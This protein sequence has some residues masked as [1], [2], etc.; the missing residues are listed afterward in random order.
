MPWFEPWV[1]PVLST[2]SPFW[3]AT[4]ALARPFLSSRAHKLSKPVISVGNIVAGGVG[5]TEMAAAIAR[6]LIEKR[7]RVVIASRGYGSSWERKGGIALDAATA[8]S[9][10]F[11]DESIVV[12]K[13]APGAMVA[14][15]ADRYAVLTRHWEELNPDVVI[16]DDGFQ[17]F[18]LARDLDVLVHDFSLRWPIL[19]DLPRVFDKAKVRVS[20]SEVPSREKGW[21]RARYRLTGAVDGAGKRHALPKKAMV[22]CGLGNPARFQKMLIDAGVRVL[23]FH[24]YPDHM[25]YTD[26][27][28]RDLVSLHRGFLKNHPDCV[29]ITSLK[30]QVKLGSFIESQGGIAGFE[31]FWAELAFEILEGEN[32][33]W[34]A[35]DETVA[36]GSA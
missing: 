11:P 19:R 18:N 34:K 32:D 3:A 9:H 31:P 24:A 16:L 4:N 35:I 36:I 25:N 29:L 21:V 17:H 5:K 10:R 20:L 6:H 15:G 7:K 8:V 33:L 22:F 2:L 28:V 23:G 1:Q 30:D 12:L 14:V 26:R 27:E 13:R